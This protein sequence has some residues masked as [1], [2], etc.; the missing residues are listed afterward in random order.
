M[1][2]RVYAR[3]L[4]L[5][6]GY[7]PFKVRTS[8]SLLL[9]ECV[10][11]PYLWFSRLI[12]APSMRDR[13][14]YPLIRVVRPYL[15]YKYMQRRKKQWEFFLSAGFSFIFAFGKRERGRED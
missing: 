11:K 6:G 3:L 15:V 13:P 12:A 9:G 4:L 7:K 2:Q 5:R 10:I 1:Q 14:F 8:L